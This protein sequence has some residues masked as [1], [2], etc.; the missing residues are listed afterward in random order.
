M[1]IKNLIKADFFINPESYGYYSHCDLD[2]IW[3][4]IIKPNIREIEN[5]KRITNT[6][7]SK[8]IKSYRLEMQKLC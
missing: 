6:A 4:E 2:A 8:H 1:K 7:I 5:T 3:R